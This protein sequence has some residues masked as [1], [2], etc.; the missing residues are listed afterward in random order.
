MNILRKNKNV[1]EPTMVVECHSGG[2]G[3]K[4]SCGSLLEVSPKDIKC[5]YIHHGE[6]NDVVYHYVTCPI[7]GAKVEVEYRLIPKEIRNLI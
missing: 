2:Y 5:G 7:C 4:I 6:E 1:N 3:D